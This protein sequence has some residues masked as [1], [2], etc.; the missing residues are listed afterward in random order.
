MNSLGIVSYRQ[1]ATLSKEDL[2]QISERVSGLGK[3]IEKGHWVQK[4]KKLAK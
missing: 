2:E 1:L 4:A 3:R